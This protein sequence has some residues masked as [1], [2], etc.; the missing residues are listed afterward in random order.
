[1]DEQET[2]KKVTQKPGKEYTYVSF[3]REKSSNICKSKPK[4]EVNIRKSK[5]QIN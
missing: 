1:M 2:S 5:R 3:D 4:T